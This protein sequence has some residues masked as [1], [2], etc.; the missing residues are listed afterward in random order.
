METKKHKEYKFKSLIKKHIK[1]IPNS[2]FFWKRMLQEY[3][4]EKSM[5]VFLTTNILSEKLR[6]K[7]IDSIINI[8][9][10]E[11]DKL[12]I[13]IEE[14]KKSINENK[15]LPEY[16]KEQTIKV[17]IYPINENI[18]QLYTYIGKEKEKFNVD[19]LYNLVHDNL[20]DI[21]DD[22]KLDTQI[23]HDKFREEWD[24]IEAKIKELMK[25]KD[26][27]DEFRYM[28]FNFIYQMIP[29]IDKYDELYVDREYDTKF[30]PKIEKEMRIKNKGDIT[31][32]DIK[33]IFLEPHLE[34]K[35]IDEII[36]YWNKNVKNQMKNHL[37]PYNEG[38]INIKNKEYFFNVVFHYYK[39]FQHF[40]EPELN[41]KNIQ[42]DWD[43][44]AKP[45][46]EKL[47]QLS[48]EGKSIK[49][50]NKSKLCDFIKS[51][52]INKHLQR[53]VIEYI[54]YEL[55]MKIYKLKFN[56]KVK[57]VQELETV[58]PKIVINKEEPVKSWYESKEG[59][60]VP[61]EEEIKPLYFQIYDVLLPRVNVKKSQ[62]ITALDNIV[63]GLNEW[64]YTGVRMS[65]QYKKD[66]EFKE[67]MTDDINLLKYIS[68]L[69]YLNPF[70]I[71]VE[72]YNVSHLF[73]PSID[74]DIAYV[75]NWAEETDFERYKGMWNFPV[76]V[77]DVD[78][79][80]KFLL[81]LPYPTIDWVDLENHSI[82]QGTLNRFKNYI[83]TRFPNIEIDDPRLETKILNM[84]KAKQEGKVYVEEKKE[85][86]EKKNDKFWEYLNNLNLQGLIDIFNTN[87]ELNGK[88]K[89]YLDNPNIL[90]VTD[91]DRKEFIYNNI[92][93]KELFSNENYLDELTSD[94]LINIIN[95]DDITKNK[96]K[97]LINSRK[98]LATPTIA[99]I[100][101]EY[102][103]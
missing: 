60:I 24:L 3:S 65:E 23:D 10:L 41:D 4:Q 91:K 48:T 103:K 87:K 57:L 68:T 89:Y 54:E 59:K 52:L 37:D 85:K 92:T 5:C 84:I 11:I 61:I 94:Q 69:K 32:D 66:K 99:N 93:M 33:D 62:V 39:Q 81:N 97:S 15:L 58:I 53:K 82:R 1:F 22:L 42:Y 46:L 40:A 98:F 86:E 88:W 9:K 64:Y 78:E 50:V 35:N 21:Y 7:L 14:I 51:K 12:N 44:V 16:I 90:Y 83:T 38:Y 27:L 29:N 20:L 73:E 13:Y 100:I 43:D 49:P 36:N 72:F 102:Y 79:Y 76:D 19:D 55:A 2:F 80:L 95:L 17:S 34:E 45:E 71:E 63:N 25:Q 18:L 96:Y 31:I 30:K 101:Y 74:S 70:L 47:I 28:Y 77:K 26:F 6:T 75:Y 67:S 8:I 56:E